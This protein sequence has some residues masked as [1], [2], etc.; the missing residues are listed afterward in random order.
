MIAVVLITVKAQIGRCY[1]GDSG[2]HMRTDSTCAVIRDSRQTG[3]EIHSCDIFQSSDNLSI[4]IIWLNRLNQITVLHCC[5]FVVLV[6][7]PVRESPMFNKRRAASGRNILAR[8]INTVRTS[9]ADR[10]T[11]TK[12]ITHDTAEYP[13]LT[14]AVLIL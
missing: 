9:K 5:Y 1:D 6:S 10:D 8:P 2:A 12:E 14:T 7:P 4:N 11:S 3:A 13:N